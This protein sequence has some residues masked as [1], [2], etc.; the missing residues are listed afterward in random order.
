M[1]NFLKYFPF[2]LHTLKFLSE[3]ASASALLHLQ[4]FVDAEN[5]KNKVQLNNILGWLKNLNSE[6]DGKS[7]GRGLIVFSLFL[8]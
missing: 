3:N 6:I 5:L 7:R 1:Y 2:G 4:S 8:L